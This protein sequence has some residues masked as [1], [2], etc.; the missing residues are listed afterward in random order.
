MTRRKKPEEK[1]KVRAVVYRNKKGE[2]RFSLL[3]PYD[4]AV[5]LALKDPKAIDEIVRVSHIWIARIEQE[6]IDNVVN[7]T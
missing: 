6:G 4:F 3:M 1:V 7:R 2:D 5:M